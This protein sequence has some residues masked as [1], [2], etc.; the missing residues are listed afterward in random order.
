RL[1]VFVLIAHEIVQGETVMCCD[2]I[3]AGRRSA[4]VVLEKIA[5]A[6]KPRCKLPDQAA[7]SLP[8]SANGVPISAIPFRPAGR[9]IADLIAGFAEVPGR[10]HQRDLLDHRVLLDDT[11]KGAEAL[12]GMLFACKRRR[13]VEPK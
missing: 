13:E 3:D 6:R 8:V 7:V 2:E 11:E 1:V 12:H 5:R 10:R 4:P 9:E